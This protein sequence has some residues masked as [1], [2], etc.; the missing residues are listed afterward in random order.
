MWRRRFFYL[1][2][3]GALQGHSQICH[4]VYQFY[5]AQEGSSTEKLFL[6]QYAGAEHPMPLSDQLKQLVELHRAAELAM[7]DFI[8][9]M[10][11]GEPLPASYFGLIKQ[12]VNAYPWLEVIKRTVCI[13]GARRSLAR[14][15]VHLGKLDAEKLM[16]DGPP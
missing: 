14:A 7:K 10:W 1:P 3:S 2:E 13:E 6:S 5:C 12:M 11:P 8:V 15:N 16:K 9:Q 4:A